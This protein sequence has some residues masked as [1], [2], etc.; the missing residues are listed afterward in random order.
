MADDVAGALRVKVTGTVCG[1][2]A[3]P[4]A[5]IV[6]VALYVPADIPAVLTLTVM[7]SVSVVVV[8]D[9]VFNVNQDALWLAVQAR[10]PPPG[11]VTLT[12]C[13]AGLA[14][15]WVAVNE[16][17]V[18]LSLIVGAALT[19]RVTG[20]VCGV[21][22]APVAE[23]VMVP[24]YVPAAR[25]LMFT[26]AATD[27]LPVPEVGLRLNQFTLSLTV[28]LS[29]PEPEFVMLTFWLAGFA[30]PCVAVKV[31]LEGLRLIV[32]L[33]AA[34]TVSVTGTVCGV[35]VAPLPAIVMAAL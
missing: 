19:V 1:V 10:V 16:R 17:L 22:V 4:L 21:L 23:I 35:F 8:P 34:F 7:G 24:L 3:A 26:L 11:F 30:P 14:A 9:A 31:K 6:I 12:V 13:A 27:P 5:V 28:Q 2:F 20:T 25:P 29:V 33:G 18:G 15:P 32:G